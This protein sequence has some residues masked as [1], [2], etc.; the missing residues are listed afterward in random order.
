MVNR[1][2]AIQRIDLSG[3]EDG[4]EWDD[5]LTGAAV[6]SKEDVETQEPSLYKV[7]LHNDDFTPMEFVVLILEKYFAK[8]HEEANQIML[9]VHNQGFG[10]CGIFPHEI[11]ETKIALVTE[12]ARE[13]QYPLKCTMERE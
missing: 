3:A 1:I 5:P 9:A 10:V 7:I 2:D 6:V 4:T 12:S 8:K 13:Q 11:A